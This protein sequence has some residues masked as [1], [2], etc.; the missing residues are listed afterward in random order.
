M[1]LGH[2]LEE[3]SVICRG[4]RFLAAF[5]KVPRIPAEKLRGKEGIRLLVESLGGSWG[6]TTV[7]EK[8]HFF[9][10]A[11]FQC[12]QKAEESNDSYLARHDA[13]FEEL[14]ARNTQLQEL[15]AYVLLRHSQLHPEDKKRVVI[16]SKGDLDYDT[17]VKA[18][19]LLG[20]KF[21]NEFQGRGG[22]TQSKMGER[23]KVYDINM[24]QGEGEDEEAFYVNEDYGVRGPDHRSCPGK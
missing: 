17:T 8:Y 20:S 12:Q 16:E 13:F 18:V 1:A 11:I 22:G 14:L 3:T 10:Q 19:R 21:F 2:R 23:Q 6:K 7:E 5:Q 4:S 24:A 15:R 9:E